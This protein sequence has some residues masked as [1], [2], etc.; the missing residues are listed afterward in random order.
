MCRC[1]Q[2]DMHIAPPFLFSSLKF[3]ANVCARFVHQ[4]CRKMK[5]K[6]RATFVCLKKKV[7]LDGGP[8]CVVCMDLS[9]I[10]SNPHLN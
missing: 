9:V 3:D 6:V 10:R 1:G 2:V 4:F 8:N 5:L 7:R